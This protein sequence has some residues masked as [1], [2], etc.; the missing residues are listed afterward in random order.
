ME[1]ME[2]RIL[3]RDETFLLTLS[4]TPAARNSGAYIGVR[5]ESRITIINDDSKLNHH[6][7]FNSKH[8]FYYFSGPNDA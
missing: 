4:L 5:N 3:E 8:F 6:N 7:Y 1:V 2:G